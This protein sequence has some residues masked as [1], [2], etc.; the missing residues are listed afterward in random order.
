MRTACGWLGVA[1]LLVLSE[2]Q[3]NA[4]HCADTEPVFDVPKLEGITVDG[5]PDDWGAGG[6]CASLL[7]PVNGWSQAAALRPADDHD[8]R[9][10]LGWNDEGLLALVT[11]CDDEWLEHPDDAWLFTHDAI[12]MFLGT[13]RGAPDFCQ[14]V[15]APGMVPDQTEVRWHSYDHRSDPAITDRPLTIAVARTRSGQGCVLEVLLPWHQLGIEPAVGREVGFQ[16]WVNDLDSADQGILTHHVPW[17]RLV[18]TNVGSD[19][20]NRVRL[21]TGAS[22]PQ[23]FGAAVECDLDR[24]HPLPQGRLAA[25]GG[26]R[27]PG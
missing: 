21:A 1:A 14:W 11:L 10:R 20:M 19:R 23:H 24:G 8:V 17:H 26:H 18:G 3:P 6:L 25:R 12:E 13:R 5:R 9:I 2:L 16:L 7:A 27:H 4:A 15:I 22:P